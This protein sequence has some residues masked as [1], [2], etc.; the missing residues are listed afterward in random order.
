M[1]DGVDMDRVAVCRR[2]GLFEG[3][4]DATVRQVFG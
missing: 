3:V 2:D 1:N 4:V